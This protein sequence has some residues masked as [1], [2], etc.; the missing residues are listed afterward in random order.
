MH[1]PDPL[2]GRGTLPESLNTHRGMHRSGGAQNSPRPEVAKRR[3]P[4]WKKWTPK[5]PKSH[6]RVHLS[7]S[8]AMFWPFQARGHFPFSFPFSRFFFCRA[9]TSIAR[10]PTPN[11]VRTPV[12]WALFEGENFRQV[13]AIFRCFLLFFT[14]ETR[15]GRSFKC[16]GILQLIRV[17][18]RFFAAFCDPFTIARNSL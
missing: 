14:S 8:A 15:N 5:W 6:S 9:V 16:L 11:S 18:K 10:L 13:F 2:T 4:K 7:I 12:F 17:P 1:L 3:P